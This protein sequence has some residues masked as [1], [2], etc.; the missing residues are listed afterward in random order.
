MSEETT[1]PAPEATPEANTPAVLEAARGVSESPKIITETGE[2]TEGWTSKYPELE[3]VN[4]DKFKSVDALA[5]SY[6]H[7]ERQK[8]GAYYPQEDWNEEKVAS[9][10]EAAGVPETSDQYNIKPEELPEGVIWDDD[11]ANKV[12]DIAHKYHVPAKAVHE[13][14]N[15]DLEYKQG[16]GTAMTQQAEQERQQ[17]EEALRQEWG[18]NF[19]K[20][21]D[22]ASTALGEL[23][24]RSNLSEEDF[25]GLKTRFGNDPSFIKMMS[26]LSSLVAE[27]KMHGT[28]GSQ[29]DSFKMDA[30]RFDELSRSGKVGVDAA[31]T[32]E[33]DELSKKLASK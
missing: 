19:D 7:L 25:Q 27:G 22:K 1:A 10:R 4:L 13:L 18:M 15:A 9:Y 30:E 33:W 29:A 8:G 5:K 6:A 24:K 31:A 11:Y 3:G 28:S 14:V 20:N 23:A 17:A 21:V 12:A 32:R 16:L 26:N 2:F